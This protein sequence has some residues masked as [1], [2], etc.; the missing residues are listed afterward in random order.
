MGGGGATSGTWG[1]RWTSENNLQSHFGAPRHH[2]RQ[3]GYSNA[4]QYSRGATNNIFNPN[5]IVG[6]SLNQDGRVG[7]FN[8]I[9]GR[10]T[11]VNANGRI[12]TYFTPDKGREYFNE[13]FG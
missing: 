5:T 9:T 4:Q 10:L 11:I 2:G 8:R 6:N 13:H 3:M 7:Y 12:I 1:Q